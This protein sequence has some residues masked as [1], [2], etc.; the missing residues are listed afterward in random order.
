MNR[1]NCFIFIATGFF[2]CLLPALSAQTP[3]QLK[4]WLIP[5]PGWELPQAAEVFHPD[6]LFDRINGAAPLFIEN[7]FREM[8]S[9]EYKKGDDY[10][11]IQ[12]YRHAT[13]EDAFGMYAAERSTGLAYFP[14]GGEAQGDEKNLYFFAGCIYVKMWSNRPDDDVRPALHAI[15]KELADRIDPAASYP[16]ITNCFPPEGKIPHTEAYITSGYIGHEF[17]KGVYTANYESGEQTFQL[18][19][20]D[21]KSKEEAKKTLVSYFTFTQQPLAFEEGALQIKDKYNGHLPVIWKGRYLIGARNENGETVQG[22]EA[23]LEAL[24]G[25]LP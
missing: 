5:V 21:G 3:E 24:A 25:K 20:L 2:L 9:L 12:A 22:A 6:N 4:S 10:I 13:P 18:F 16:P 11:T 1:L 23:L 15:G 7:N 19:V 17:L 14:L 8:T